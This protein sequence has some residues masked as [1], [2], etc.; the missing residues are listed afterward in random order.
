M[1]VLDGGHE[2]KLHGG[3]EEWDWGRPCLGCGA[4]PEPLRPHWEGGLGPLSCPLPCPRGD[5]STPP[6]C[7]APRVQDCGSRP[8]LGLGSLLLDW[9]GGS[10]CGVGVL[11]AAVGGR[12]CISLLPAGGG[13]G[14][15]SD[16]RL[17]SVPT[18]RGYPS[19]AER[20]CGSGLG[21][22]HGPYRGPFTAL[23]ASLH[24]QG[25]SWFSFVNVE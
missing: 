5:P 20:L 10:T 18:L 1:L 4:D 3:H 13:L 6:P 16:C 19:P 7:G 25:G 15:T 12:P 9:G 8:W 23:R 21:R 11:P 17:G 2:T 14:V 24:S 22:A